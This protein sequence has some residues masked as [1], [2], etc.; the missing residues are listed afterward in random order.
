MAEEKDKPKEEEKKKEAGAEGAEGAEAGAEGAEGS[1]KF[2]KKKLI[3]II[4]AA[5]VLLAGGGGAAFFLTKNKAPAPGEEGAEA[6][7]KEVI[8]DEHGN[9]IEVD[10]TKAV[11]IDLDEFLVNLNTGGKQASFLKMSV[12]LELASIKDK[13]KIEGDIPRIR[14]A[15]QIYLRELRSSDLQGSAGMHRLREELLLRINKTIHPA[16]VTDILFKEI[17]VQ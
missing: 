14:D 16:S 9:P 15:F 17:I 5:V 7:E 10:P 12:T 8:L 13:S 3:I 4:I 2:G 6:V 1:K 11:Y